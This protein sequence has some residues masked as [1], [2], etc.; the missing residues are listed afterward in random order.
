MSRREG[1]MHFRQREEALLDWVEL[2]VWRR[3]DD[4]GKRGLDKSRWGT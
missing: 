1:T 3:G 2:G 4:A